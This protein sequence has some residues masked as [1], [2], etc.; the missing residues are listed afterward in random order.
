MIYY[1]LNKVESDIPDE[2]SKIERHIVDIFHKN[3]YNYGT[4][5]IKEVLHKIGYQASKR[6]ISRIMKENALVSNYAV[7]QYKVHNK[8]CNESSVSN[9][10]DRDFDNRDKLEVAISDLTYV[11][12]GNSWNYVC[13]LIDLTNREIIGY[14]AGANKDA[15]LIEKALLRCRYSLKDIKVFHSDRGKEVRQEVA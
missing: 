6:R 7:A 1:Y 8:G 11:R 2:E 10:V 3:R 9:I 12:V 5:K 13:T 4:R 15:S 14:S